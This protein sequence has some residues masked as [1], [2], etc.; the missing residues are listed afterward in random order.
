MEK[1][2]AIGDV[3]GLDSWKDAVEAHP[4]CRV[5]FLGDYLD[6]YFY[7]PREKLLDNLRDIIDLKKS[8]PENVV[9]LL[10]NHDLHYFSEYAC[11]G[12]RFDA[13]IAPDAYRLFTDNIRLFQY[14]FQDGEYLFTHAGVSRKWFEDDFRGDAEQPVADQ[15]NNPDES[16]MS[17]LFRV[18]YARGGSRGYMGGIFWAD[19]SELYNPLHGFVQIVGHNRVMKVTERDG[20]GDSR[21]IFCDCLYNGRYLCI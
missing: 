18:G 10:G 4:E 13:D 19:E 6:P 20:I 15:L 8:R 11:R 21:I 3:H 9:L 17:A 12:T 14:A 5:V 7:V 2:V 16:R 1:T